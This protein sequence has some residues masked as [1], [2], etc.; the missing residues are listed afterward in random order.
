MKKII[1]KTNEG[2]EFFYN[3]GDTYQ[4]SN[5]SAEIICN[6]MNAAKYQLKP[7]ELWKVYTVADYTFKY[8]TMFKA[9]RNR[10]KVRFYEIWRAI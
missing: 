9:I 1:A 7:G 2:R 8:N 4:V 10:G 3:R 6:S 5:A